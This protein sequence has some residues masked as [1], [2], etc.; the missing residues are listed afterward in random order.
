VTP[1]R[2]VNDEIEALPR[3]VAAAKRRPSAEARTDGRTKRESGHKA[4]RQARAPGP[5]HKATGRCQEDS[6]DEKRSQTEAAVTRQD[7]ALSI[8]GSQPSSKRP[9]RLT[10]DKHDK[11]A[12]A[13]FCATWRNRICRLPL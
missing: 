10:Y 8:A 1:R 13:V 4:S 12:L 5:R 2:V 9:C 7:V 11:G 3:D 6:G